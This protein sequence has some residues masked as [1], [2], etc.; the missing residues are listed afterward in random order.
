MRVALVTSVGRCGIA[1][2]SEMLRHAVRTA[3]PD[4]EFSVDPAWLNPKA[5]PEPYGWDVIHLNYHRGLHSQWTPQVIVDKFAGQG[6]PVVITFHDTYETQPDTLARELL[7]CPNVQFMVVHEPCDLQDSPKVRYWRQP[8]PDSHGRGYPVDSVTAFHYNGWRP[9]LGTLGFDFPWKNYTMLAK[10]TG[11]LGWN[12]RIVG[13]VDDA[14]KMALATLNPNI[15]FDGYVDSKIDA[16][17][18]L[19]S[20][21]ATAFIYTCAN[22][23]TSGAI[24]VGMTAGKPLIAG[25]GCRQ[26]RDLEGASDAWPISWVSPDEAGLVEGLVHATRRAGP[27][28]FHLGLIHLAHENSWSKIG[29]RYADLYELA[30]RRR[31]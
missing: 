11:E 16:V 17:A 27:S 24:R 22:S 5:G 29:P 1:E 26:F 7:A 13:Q 10:V 15:W 19:A 14:R 23:G 8:C 18:K 6:T 4:I 12:L 21:D 2:H 3:N 25:T 28:G 30:M 9:T 20:C 31:A